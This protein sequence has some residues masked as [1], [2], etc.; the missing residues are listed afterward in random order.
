MFNLIKLSLAG[1]LVVGLSAC[2]E[3]ALVP[4]SDCDKVVAHATKVLG[5]FAP[6]GDEMLKQCKAASDKVRGCVMAADKPMKLT[7]CDF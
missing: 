2:G 6:S 4:E 7:Q 3:E 5:K 1:V